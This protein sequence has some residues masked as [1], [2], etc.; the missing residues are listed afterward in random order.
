MFLI[1]RGSRIVATAYTFAYAVLL[2]NAA[3][4]DVNLVDPNGYVLL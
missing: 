4:D 3:G 1:I 2:Y